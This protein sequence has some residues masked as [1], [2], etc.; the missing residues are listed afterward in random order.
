MFNFLISLLKAFQDF[1]NK[2][3]PIICEFFIEL[4][5]LFLGEGGK[6]NS[7]KT[8]IQGVV[9][10]SKTTYESDFF[11]SEREEERFY[12]DLAKTIK[13]CSIRPE[14]A[15]YLFCSDNKIEGSKIHNEMNNFLMDPHKS[16]EIVT[17]LSNY[18][19]LSDKIIPGGVIND[20]ASI[21]FNHYL[22]R[23]IFEPKSNFTKAQ[24]NLF[25]YRIFKAA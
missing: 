24:Y 23:K 10:S 6:G 18:P 16:L 3:I 13:K 25:F 19:K 14:L 20:K 4:S 11:E 7:D 17:L 5:N 12:S 9:V 22:F 1:V 8:P 2:Y 21:S 15:Y